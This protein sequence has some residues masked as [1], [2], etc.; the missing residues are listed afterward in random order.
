MQ[1]IQHL[2][3]ATTEAIEAT[4]QV[5]IKTEQ[6]LVNVTKPEIEGDY[7]VVLFAFVKQLGKSPDELGNALGKAVMA[8]MPGTI[9]AYNIV[10]DF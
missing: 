10:K 9:T 6:V 2:R 8:S 3:Q 5:Q 7:T 4:Y 1:L